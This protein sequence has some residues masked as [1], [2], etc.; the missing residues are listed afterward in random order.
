MDCWGA[1]SV[2]TLLSGGL[3]WL[4]GCAVCGD[5]PQWWS[6]LVVGVRCLWRHSSVVFAMGLHW[7]AF[8]EGIR[9]CLCSHRTHQELLLLA[10]L[11]SKTCVLVMR[12]RLM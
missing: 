11:Y 10:S 7:L 3:H 12:G 6:S 1:L 5:T 2:E 8:K 4:L 9:L